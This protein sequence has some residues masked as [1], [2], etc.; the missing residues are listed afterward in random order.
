MIE[1]LAGDQSEAEIGFELENQMR[2]QGAEKCS[3]EPIV[4]AGPSSALAHYH[5]QRKSIGEHEFLL[6][7]WGTQLDGYASDLTRMIFWGEIDPRMEEIYNVVLAAQTAAIN[8]IREGAEFTAIDHAARSVIAEAGYG[9]QFS[10]GLGHGIGLEIHEHPFLSPAFQGKL[11]A[12]MVITIE[13]GIYLPGV[14]G[15]R[16]EDDVLVKPDGFEILSKLPRSFESA[17]YKLRP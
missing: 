14:G 16:I 3:F 12:E 4:A 6:L 9:D 17:Q 5:G 11:E 8:E 1:N 10:H 15:V 2:K 7:D 13:P